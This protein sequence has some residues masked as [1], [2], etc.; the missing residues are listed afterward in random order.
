M[1]T[2]GLIHRGT[3]VPPDDLWPRLRARLVAADDVVRVPIPA[4][5]WREVTAA[6]VAVA[7]VVLAPDPL[8]FLAASGVL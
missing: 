7:A 5:G 3:A 6:A 1:Q 2:L 8:G 4:L